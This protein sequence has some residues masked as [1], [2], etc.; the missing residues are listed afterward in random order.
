MKE[1]HIEFGDL[2]RDG[3]LTN[4]RYLSNE[5]IKKCP[6]FIL[7]PEHYKEDGTCLCLDKGHQLE[8]KLERIARREKILAAQ[9]KINQKR[10]K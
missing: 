3:K 5:T 6:L 2:T 1:G 4:V 10:G 8:L 7:V 9:A